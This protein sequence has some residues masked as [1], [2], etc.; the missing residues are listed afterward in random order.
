ML[1]D[2]KKMAEIISSRIGAPEKEADPNELDP[3]ILSASEDM[4]SAMHAKDASGFAMALKDFL[5]MHDAHED[6]E[7][8]EVED[9][10][11]SILG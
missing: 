2:K 3:G 8:P 7:A 1:G 11:H 10:E 5:E 6:S 9:K 4:M